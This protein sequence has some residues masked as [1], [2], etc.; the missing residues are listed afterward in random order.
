MWVAV[1]KIA[2]RSKCEIWGEGLYLK[3][4]NGLIYL[5]MVAVLYLVYVLIYLK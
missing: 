1:W 4:R 2:G 3:W 5:G